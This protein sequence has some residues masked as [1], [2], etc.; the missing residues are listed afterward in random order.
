MNREIL[1]PTIS[2]ILASW[3]VMGCVLNVVIGVLNWR[4][5][6]DGII[7]AIV[8]LVVFF[9]C[10]IFC[11]IFYNLPYFKI[12]INDTHIIGPRGLGG[13]WQRI[14]MPLE[15]IDMQNINSALQWFGFYIIRSK[16]GEKLSVWGFDKKQFNRLLGLVNDRRSLMH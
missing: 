13:G 6:E 4:D 9:Q 11:L 10:F 12:E 5:I 16:A 1:K 3:L 14:E 15:D 7:A 8:V 2:K